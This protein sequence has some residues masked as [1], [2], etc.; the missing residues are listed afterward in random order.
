MKF[1]TDNQAA[2]TLFDANRRTL[3]TISVAYVE[4]YDPKTKTATVTIPITD[5]YDTDGEEPLNL[6]WKPI[7]DIPVIFFRAGGWSQTAPLKKGDPVLLLFCQRSIDEWF[8]T[9]GKTTVSPGFI[10]TH[11]EKD[12][13][14]LAGLFPSKNNDGESDGENFIIAHKDGNQFYFTPKAEAAIV[15]TKLLI[16]SKT[17]ATALAKATTTDNNF[18]T[19]RTKL[20]LV[21]GFLGIPPIGTLPATA[22]GKAFT[23]D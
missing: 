19:L 14:A 22:S 6:D 7:P 5:F 11:D 8:A 16:G 9:D 20:D 12:C 1:K 3:N 15:A 17:A 10:N 18:T 2:D 21:C 4:S 23:N 13:L